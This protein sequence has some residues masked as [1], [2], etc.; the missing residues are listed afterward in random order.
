MHKNS[1]RS[2]KMAMP[3][4]GKDS[5]ECSGV[6]DDGLDDRGVRLG[7]KLGGVPLRRRR[8]LV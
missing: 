8:V 1:D 3:R 2:L 7:V 6:M 4:S 5:A